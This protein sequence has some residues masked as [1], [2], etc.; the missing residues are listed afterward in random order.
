[1]AKIKKYNVAFLVDGSFLPIRNGA[2]YSIYH[3]MN[4]LY[5]TKIV[6]PNLII[7][8][9]GWDNPK[10]YYKQLFRTI[11]L[12]TNDYYCDTGVLN[13]VFNFHNIKY[14]H[15]YNAEEVLNLGARLKKDGIKIIYEAINIDH[16]LYGQL[17]KN[18]KK[19]NQIKNLQREAMKLADEVLCRSDIDKGHI[20]KMKINNKKITVYRGA[21]SVKNIKYQLRTKKRYKVIFLGHMYYPPNENSL[22]LIANKILPA[23]KKINHKYS[24]TI[25]GV[26][27][28][29][30]IKKYGKRGI[31][32]KGGIDNLGQELLNYDIGI[33]PLFEGSGT[34]LK[35]LDFL[36]SGMPVI[37]SSLGI[38]GLQKSI[39]NCLIIENNINKYAVKIEQIMQNL[40]EC[41]KISFRGRRFVEQY[42]NWNN[43][44]KPFLNIYKKYE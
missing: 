34:R 14:V 42:Y 43:N 31:I 7:S 11:F 23:L 26:T 20:L 37:T 27:P 38:E 8:Y 35:I 3:L 18:K 9:R 33:V 16:I 13:Y 5:R 24:I 21:I 15:I 2:Y 4:S 41:G 30:I 28:V 40:K 17:I 1:M 39:N 6:A 44:L 36:A 10:L 12:P 19:I 25:I 32:F 29:A 22:E